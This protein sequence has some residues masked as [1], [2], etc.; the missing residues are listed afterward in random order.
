MPI[1]QTRGTLFHFQHL[2]RVIFR[3]T[4]VQR[5]TQGLGPLSTYSVAIPPSNKLAARRA[6]VDSATWV[7][8]NGSKLQTPDPGYVVAK[9]NKREAASS[10]LCR[11]SLVSCF[12]FLVKG[13][14][15]VALGNLDLFLSLLVP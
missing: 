14:L 13:R 7:N 1:P 6:C 5:G 9:K 8:E 4:S 12:F 15:V 10:F 2:W 3:A 11:P